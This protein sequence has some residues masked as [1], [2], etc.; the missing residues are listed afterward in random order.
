M[1]DFNQ[2]TLSGRL[3]KDPVSRKTANGVDES[4]FSIA[5]NMWN[6]LNK[7][8][9]VFFFD[10]VCW[11]N[12]ANYMNENIK[13]GDLVLINGSLR[14]DIVKD[15]EGLKSKKYHKII[16]NVVKL[17]NKKNTHNL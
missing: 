4:C 15:K 13:K 10:C 5:I 17:M 6:N 7:E 11:N 8:E 16:C 3:S 12:N 14:Y 9:D 1:S 2:I